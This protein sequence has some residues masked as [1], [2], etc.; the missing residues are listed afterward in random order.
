M[1]S[2]HASIIASAA[3]L[4]GEPL[5]DP[6]DLGGSDRSIVLRARTSD[7]GAIVLKKYADNDQARAV[8]T[9]ESAGL[10]FTDFGPKLLAADLERLLVVMSDLGVHASLADRLLDQDPR[11]AVEALLEWAGTYGR[12]AAVT[13]GR[14]PDLARLAAQYG[15]GHEPA[16]DGTWFAEYCA[17]FPTRL[18]E[19][20][21]TAPAGLEDELAGLRET[22][23]S[24]SFAVFS[25]GDICPDNNLLTP[26]GLRVLD[27]E[28]ASFHSVFLD[29][30][31]TA[32]P[33]ATCWCVFRLPPGLSAEIEQ[34]Y[35]SE[36]TAAF[37]ALADD[38]IWQPGMR[39]AVALWTV[40]MSAGMI[41]GVLAADKPMHSTR[42]PA[43]TARQVLHH[44]WT[45]LR[46]MLEPTGELPAITSC[47]IAL[48]SATAD[49]KPGPLPLYPALS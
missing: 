48:L 43:S 23:L 12:I 24:G 33:F 34:R 44:R 16:S 19:L 37:P 40:T 6:V 45:L 47:M 10:A 20:G 27:F 1:D 31:Y 14:R 15:Q 28:S 30:A 35:R 32:M 49:W 26:D 3:E 42:R 17:A 18:A 46:D 9:A 25:P 39:A 7:G 11:A 8:F 22:L 41:K 2:T 36:V 29:A 4:L 5:T 21:I 38:S 13:A